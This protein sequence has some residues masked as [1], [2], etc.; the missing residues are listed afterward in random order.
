MEFI[1]LP[2]F[3]DCFVLSSDHEGQPITLLESLQLQLPAIA[4]DLPSTR[5]VLGAGRGHLV[6]NSASGLAQAM[7]DFAHAQR[8]AAS[9]VLDTQAYQTQAWQEFLSLLASNPKLWSKPHA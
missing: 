5:A 2:P 1:W 4:T 7:H 8:S 3:R 6:D 9:V